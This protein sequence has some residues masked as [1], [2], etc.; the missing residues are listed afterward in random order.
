M[1]FA[2]DDGGRRETYPDWP[3]TGG[4][5]VVRAIA[6]YTGIAFKECYEILARG[7]AQINANRVQIKRKYKVALSEGR[8]G[9]GGIATTVYRPFLKIRGLHQ[10]WKAGH[11]EHGLTAEDAFRMF[12]DCILVAKGANGSHMTCIRGGKLRDTFDPSTREWSIGRNGMYER[13]TR[14][15]EV[16]V[17]RKLV[18]EDDLFWDAGRP[19]VTRE[20]TEYEDRPVPSDVAE[21]LETRELRDAANRKL[22]NAEKV[23]GLKAEAARLLARCR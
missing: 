21:K 11:G 12:G 23:K 17:W 5:C 16:W 8:D 20:V 13:K 22:V 9:D 6:T 19:R 14:F 1:E 3:V 4:D 2:W 18:D 10:V 15:Y 7:Q